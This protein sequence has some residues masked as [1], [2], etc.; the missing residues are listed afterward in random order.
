MFLSG[1]GRQACDE[2]KASRGAERK[3]DELR[4]C[5]D[6]H[7]FILDRKKRAGS[8]VGKRVIFCPRRCYHFKEMESKDKKK[9]K[10]KQKKE[11]VRLRE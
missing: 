10:K 6:Q 3:M 5:L 4:L 11:K 8:E 9:K 1:Q 7:S 2:D